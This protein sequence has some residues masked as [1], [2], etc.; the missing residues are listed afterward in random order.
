[1]A[2]VAN[3][4]DMGIRVWLRRTRRHVVK[5][6]G[7]RLIRALAHIQAR[8]SLAGTEPVLDKADFQ[9]AAGLESDWRTIRKEFDRLLPH[10]DHIPN[11]H[12][13]S[14]DQDRISKGD[15]WKTF[16]L[17]GFGYRIDENCK[18]CPETARLL[19]NV[20][21]LRT[22]FFSILAPG[23]RIPPHRG[24]TKGVVR[25]HLCLIAPDR[26]ESCW[27]RVGD[28]RVIWREGECVV[29]DD[30]FEHEVRNDTDQRRIVLLVDVDRPMR[31]FGRVIHRLFMAA[32]RASDYVQGARRNLMTGDGRLAAA[33]EEADASRRTSTSRPPAK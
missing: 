2:H 10:A 25:G 17:F 12:E 11:F 20:P 13:V 6:A 14:P 33:V 8:Q 32:I 23:Y 19:E 3:A 5:Q 4:S 24:V 16:V 26:A 28:Q 1:M 22:A 29:F 30:T 18:L 9:W 21:G 7:K 27:M 31:P 15:N